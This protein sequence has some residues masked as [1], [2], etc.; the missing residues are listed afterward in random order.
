MAEAISFGAISR[1]MLTMHLYSVN[2]VDGLY[3]LL[4]SLYML[5]IYIYISNK[6]LYIFVVFGW[7]DKPKGMYGSGGRGL[8]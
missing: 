4:N 6:G 2:A 1:G 3:I 5:S 8:S 7:G